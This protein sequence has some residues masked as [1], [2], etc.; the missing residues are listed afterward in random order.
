[1][2]TI[3]RICY[4][5]QPIKV[6]YPSG[7]TVNLG[8][9]VKPAEVKSKPDLEWPVGKANT[10]YA[11]TMVDPD[12]PSRRDPKFR[13]WNHWLVVNIQGGNINTGD[14]IIA[15]IGSG[16]PKGTGLHRYVFLIFKQ[17]SKMKFEEKF[18]S[19]K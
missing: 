4:N 11:L 16:P 12:S 6:T 8:N 17:T 14:D 5:N 19:S 18:I 1:M 15:Y 9:V 7:I 13:E 2:Y 10:Y 3:T